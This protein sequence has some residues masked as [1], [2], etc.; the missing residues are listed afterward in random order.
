MT[1]RYPE[2]IRM[3]MGIMALAIPFLIVTFSQTAGSANN[4]RLRK[5]RQSLGGAV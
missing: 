3:K 5:H 4:T 1:K 2:G